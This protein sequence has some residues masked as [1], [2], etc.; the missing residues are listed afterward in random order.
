VSAVDY[1]RLPFAAL[2]GW[3]LFSELSDVWTWIGASIIFTATLY[4]TRRELILAKKKQ[5]KNSR[6]LKET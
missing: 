5:I 1:A 3:I 2:I 6:H 4:I